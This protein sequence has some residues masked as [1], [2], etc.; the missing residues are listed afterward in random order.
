[1]PIGARSV[2]RE[3]CG[4]RGSTPG[5]HPAIIGVAA[6]PMEVNLTE[7]ERLMLIVAA[8]EGIAAT[9]LMHRLLLSLT[10][11]GVLS[12]AEAS[13]ICDAALSALE[14]S[15]ARAYPPLHDESLRHARMR[16]ESVMKGLGPRTKSSG[17]SPL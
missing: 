14:R 12:G 16:I 5:A 7:D 13:S 17:S 10:G 15:A 3:A 4:D 11:K 9:H 1:M 8:G 6:R 2:G